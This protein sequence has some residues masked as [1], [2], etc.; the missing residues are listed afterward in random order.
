MVELP[1][2][3]R[4][5]RSSGGMSDARVGEWRGGGY[6]ETCRREVSAL[7]ADASRERGCDGG[8]CGWEHTRAITWHVLPRAAGATAGW[9]PR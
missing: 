4:P 7:A 8:R 3:Q 6:A 9:P 5:G 2:R 1:L